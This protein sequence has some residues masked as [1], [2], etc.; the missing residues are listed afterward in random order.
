MTIFGKIMLAGAVALTA[1]AGTVQAGESEFLQSLHGQWTGKG[2]VKIRTHMKPISVTCNFT[3]SG[4]SSS[5]SLDG[6]CKGLV[7]FTKVISADLVSSGSRYSGAYT[8]AGT[9]KAGL[10]GARKG[11]EID[12]QIKWAKEVNGDR[13]AQ[14][15]VRKLGDNGMQLVTVDRDPKTGKQVVTSDINLRR[16]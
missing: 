3:S 2:S 11:N 14:M 15:S 12:L 7:V 10:S 13:V 1:G 9:G 5:L 8:G 4:G 16:K 6:K